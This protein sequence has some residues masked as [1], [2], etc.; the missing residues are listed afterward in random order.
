MTILFGATQDEFD[1]FLASHRDVSDPFEHATAIAWVFD[2]AAQQMLLVNHRLHGWSCPGGHLE[3]GE[4]PDAA[5]VRELHEEVGV[6]ATPLSVEP[7]VVA[8]RVGCPRAPG[9]HVVHWTYGYQ[10]EVS[11]TNVPITEPGQPARWWSLRAL[12]HD[13]TADIDEVLVAL[14]GGAN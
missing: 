10:F 3:P 13:R 11:S 9:E 4:T 1:R 14:T 2:R 6:A 7:A 5:A 12:P 8:R